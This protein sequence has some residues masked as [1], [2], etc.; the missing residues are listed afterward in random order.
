MKKF[1]TAA[2]SLALA[3][4]LTVPAFAADGLLISPGPGDTMP[5]MPI[6]AP[7]GGYATKLVV[8]E[9]A[10]DISA[11][12]AAVNPGMV[13]LRLVA[14]ADHGSAYWSEEENQGSFYMSDARITVNFAD[15]SILVGDEPFAGAAEVIRGVTF[16]PVDA[17]KGLEG[18]EVIAEDGSVT[19]T[20]PNNAPLVKLAYSIREAT[21]MAMGMKGAITD[22]TQNFELP[23]DTFAEGLTFFGMNINPDCLI[24][25]KLSEGADVDAV[26]AAMESYRQAQEET[27]TWYMG[28]HL[29]KVQAAQTVVNGD[30]IL[31]IIAEEPDKGVELFNAFVEFQK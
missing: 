26:K 6:S 7:A 18:I 11:I 24:L 17:L 28:Q 9:S 19:I 21:D 30:Y 16:V 31:F 1:G 4:T 27:F 29:P 12:P 13:P 25:G 20:T 2:L 5:V 3:A 10:L 23:E 14:E 15:N 22:F 8:N